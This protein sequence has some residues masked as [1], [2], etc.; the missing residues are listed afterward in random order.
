[1]N[2]N[3]TK[4]HLKM[5]KEDYEKGCNQYLLALLNIWELDSH[6]GF[7]VGY[8]VGEVYCYGDNIYMDMQ[9]IIFCVENNVSEEKFMEYLDYCLKCKEYN[10]N[11]PNLPSYFKGCPTIPKE[12]FDK[13]DAMKADLN[14]CIDD[15]KNG[16]GF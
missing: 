10:F 16:K 13:L 8:E 1:M 11:I 3:M 9:Q 7:W 12:T 5:L 4:G 6:Y 14:K 15:V 2:N